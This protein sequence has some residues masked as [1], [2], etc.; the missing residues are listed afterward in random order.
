MA[1]GAGLAAIQTP[2][3]AAGP[4]RPPGRCSAPIGAGP[5]RGLNAHPAAEPSRS[6]GIRP[7]TTLSAPSRG[8]QFKCLDRRVADIAL[9]DRHRRIL[10]SRSGR[11]PQPPAS[12]LCD[13][14]PR[15]CAGS[16]PGKGKGRAQGTAMGGGNAVGHGRSEGPPDRVHHSGQCA[17]PDRHEG[18]KRPSSCCLPG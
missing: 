18:G 10:P 5:D 13:T 6:A 8:F 14:K 11:P 4:M 1:H 17:D 2:G 9:T 12:M 15:P 7:K 3:R 16:L